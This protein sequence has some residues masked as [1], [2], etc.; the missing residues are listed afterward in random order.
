MHVE[1]LLDPRD[2]LPHDATRWVTSLK[3]WHCNFKSLAALS[4]YSSLQSLVIGGFPAE[5][6][7]VLETLGGLRELRVAHFPHVSEL[8]PLGSLRNLEMLSLQTDPSWHGSRRRQHVASLS[9]VGSLQKLRSVELLGVVPDAGGLQPL[10]ACR[11]L[12]RARLL[13]Y[14]VEEAAALQRALPRL[15]I[16]ES[17]A[18]NLS[19]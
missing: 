16:W 12:T 3:I 11:H 9:P 18:V 15:S 7:S 13:G 14:S 6:F 10:S 5:S 17:D 19:I 2:A 8:G 4:G 1:Y